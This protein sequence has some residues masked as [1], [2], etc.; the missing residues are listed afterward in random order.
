MTIVIKNRWRAVKQVL[1]IWQ[2]V[3]YI[4]EKKGKKATTPEELGA[5]EM[6]WY[7][8]CLRSQC[9]NTWMKL[10]LLFN[11]TSSPSPWSLHHRDDRKSDCFKIK[12]SLSGSIHKMKPG[13]FF[14]GTFKPLQHG[15]NSWLT[16]NWKQRRLELPRQRSTMK[17]AF[18]ARTWHVV[19]P[20]F[21]HR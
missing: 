3:I 4:Q 5:V 17:Y 2:S 18:V 16:G 8:D 19:D 10:M 11:P 9:S 7:V 14:R 20:R 21:H 6:S 1:P 15:Q 13:L 12:P